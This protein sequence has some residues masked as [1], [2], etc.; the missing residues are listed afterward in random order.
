MSLYQQPYDLTNQGILEAWT[1]GYIPGFKRD[2]DFEAWC[3]QVGVKK[4]SAV[5]REVVR[6]ES[7]VR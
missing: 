3:E 4:A 1:R 2:R 6:E 5:M 7:H